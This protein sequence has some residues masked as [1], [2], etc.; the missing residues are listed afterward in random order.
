MS[1]R[2][3]L[4]SNIIN[5]HLR[6]FYFKNS[7]TINKKLDQIF[8]SQ[9]SSR[10][11]CININISNNGCKL[12]SSCSTTTTS[13]IA[14]NNY[15]KNSTSFNN[16]FNSFSSINHNSISLDI[17][18]LKRSIEYINNGGQ[19][20]NSNS[21]TSE[22]QI[23]SN[24]LNEIHST[25]LSL[26]HNNN[27][28][29]FTNELHYYIAKFL[30]TWNLPR[31]YN[32]RMPN[33]DR[34]NN[35]NESEMLMAMNWL[36]VN[37][38][39]NDQLNEKFINTRLSLA[40][41]Y[42]R[43]VERVRQLV[44]DTVDRV[45]TNRLDPDSSFF[46]LIL[47]FQACPYLCLWQE[48]RTLGDMIV[49]NYASAMAMMH[50]EAQ[51]DNTKLDYHCIYLMLDSSLSY[52]ETSKQ[53]QQQ[54]PALSSHDDDYWTR[55][56]YAIKQFVYTKSKMECRNLPAE[57][58]ELAIAKFAKDNE[59]APPNRIAV[60]EE[61]EMSVLANTM[62]WSLKFEDLPTMLYTGII[63]HQNGTVNLFG[64]LLYKANESTELELSSEF[65]GRIAF[66]QNH[67]VLNGQLVRTVR[68]TESPNQTYIYTM[69][70]KLIFIKEF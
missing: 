34:L 32:D 28:Q 66:E 11:T 51:Q 36:D 31:F 60:P 18:E 9:K 46:R 49:N 69:D 26:D 39:D 50:Q 53:Q 33:N 8:I 35:P 65:A 70:T 54:Q 56:N 1:Y 43:I 42:P 19:I 5:D 64:Y 17:N 59:N 68:N 24:K 52:L 12:K 23:D 44:L 20:H 61:S 16:R 2:Y 7:N 25:I 67:I 30:M 41:E 3:I 10:P 37:V 6:K 58:E 62:R 40:M 13:L 29:Q 57:I 21:I 4:E 45:E 38:K 27:Q 47:S 63:D 55:H 15:Q 14:F 48:M 22:I